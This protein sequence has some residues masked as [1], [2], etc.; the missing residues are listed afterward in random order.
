MYHEHPLKIFRHAVTN[1]WLL[2]FPVLRGVRS[3]SLDFSTV[4]TWLKGAWFD[5]LILLFIIG[6]GYFRWIFT[7]YS[8]EKHQ[9]VF[10]SGVF[11]K[12]K[13]SVPYENISAITTEHSF[14]LRPFNAARLCIDT[15]AGTFGTA[16][17][18]LLVK[19]E[20]LK[21][22]RKRMPEMNMKSSRSFEFKPRLYTVISFSL[23]FSS[24][25]SGVIYLSTLIFQAG[26]IVK[27]VMEKGLPDV[28][29]IANNV[30]A[31]VS[32]RVPVDVPPL[33]IVLLFLLIG[34]WLLSFI[35]NI[36]RYTG[37][38]MKKNKDMMR[39]VT[40]AVTKRVYHIDPKKIN[41]VD[42]RQNF[43]MKIFRISSI[44]VNCSGYGRSKYELPVLLPILTREQTNRTLD[45]LDF[46]K[47]VTDRK[48]KPEKLACWSYISIPTYIA[49]AIPLVAH[50]ISKLF[51]QIQ[52]I[53]TTIVIMA[54]IPLLWLIIV[55]LVA[56]GTTGITM[57]DDFC[58]I[59]Y[60]RFYAFHTILADKSKLVK[61]QI[62]QDVIDEKFGR[63][64][65]D[66]YFNSEVTKVNKVKGLNI[67]DAKRII[68]KFNF[69]KD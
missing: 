59:R 3:F 1:I 6:F 48:V 33:A 12:T 49:A 5:L 27:D 25:L 43:L 38:T 56:F 18:K 51:P 52:H 10:M 39:I 32:E 41:Y 61:I 26:R 16:D 50:I 22:I 35:S 37:F 66:F 57:E 63:C 55:K 47:Y 19:R 28:Y 64:R 58:C 45:I 54:E 69:Q 8:F 53:L 36:L 42:I 65:L 40:G 46:K 21:S 44:H 13:V 9:I 60:S 4:Y 2:I 14:Y 67:K 15:R 30:S 29:E 34:T 31:D 20:H 68:E 7:W 11:I 23:I 17:M 24:S 62:F